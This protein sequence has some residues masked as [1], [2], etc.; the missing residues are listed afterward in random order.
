MGFG[1]S[2]LTPFPGGR[3]FEKI[4]DALGMT[5]TLGNSCYDG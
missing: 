1:Q 5:Q 2:V 4:E 3:C